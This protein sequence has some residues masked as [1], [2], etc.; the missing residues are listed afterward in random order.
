VVDDL[1]LALLR[2]AF[3][4]LTRTKRPDVTHHRRPAGN[5]RGTWL[6]AN[7]GIWLTLNKLLD[8]EP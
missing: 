3:V 5:G 8:G 7:V 2:S 4:V 6:F 1:N